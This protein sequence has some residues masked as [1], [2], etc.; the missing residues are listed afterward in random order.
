MTGPNELLNA[1][2]GH[3]TSVKTVRIKAIATPSAV[4]CERNHYLLLRNTTTG[5]LTTWLERHRDCR[6]VVALR[7]QNVAWTVTWFGL[8]LLDL[9]WVSGNVQHQ[10]HLEVMLTFVAATISYFIGTTIIHSVYRVI[11]DR[12]IK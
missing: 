7:W 5:E 4:L 9:W 1:I 3:D 6:P 2:N 8:A 10:S 12:R 11:T